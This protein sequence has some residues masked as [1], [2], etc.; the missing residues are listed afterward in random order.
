MKTKYLKLSF[1][2]TFIM[3]MAACSSDKEKSSEKEE[4][5]PV[6]KVEQASSQEVVQNGVYTASVE[7]EIINNISSSTPNRIKQIL[8]DEGM[9]V[10]AGQTL[11]ILDDVNS[12]SYQIQVDNAKANLHNVQVNY[13]R[14]LELFKIGG[15]TKQ[16]VDQMETQLINAKNTLAAAERAL[17]NSRENTV[18]TSPISGV[19]TAR[20]YDPGDMTS[21]LP[22]LTVAQVQP[23]KIV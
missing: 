18:L 19:V 1:L 7:P 12:T 21:T 22:I 8:V 11:V 23:V 16:S 6:V 3:V 4:E 10:S 13:D 15:G 14:A 20:N 9:R 2:A 5:K 17:R